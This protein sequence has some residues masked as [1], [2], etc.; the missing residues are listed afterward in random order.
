MNILNKKHF[1]YLAVV[2]LIVSLGY[3]YIY[4]N[5][6]NIQNE[7]AIFIITTEQIFN[8]FQ[9]NIIVANN[10]YLDKVIIIS[11]NITSIDSIKI[12]LNNKLMSY[13]IENHSNSIKVGDEITIK[14]RCIGYDEL[15]EI[16]K[17]DQCIILK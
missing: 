12:E 10:K 16:V 9:T 11:G 1:I 6:R 14:G 15:L 2:G 7:E 17:I 5:H 13:L 3:S 8:E 4:K